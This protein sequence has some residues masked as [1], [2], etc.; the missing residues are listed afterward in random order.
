MSQTQSD[1]P[2]TPFHPLPSFRTGSRNET[3][4]E[5]GSAH[6]LRVATG[7]STKNSSA[8]AIIRNLQEIGGSLS[9]SGD[10]ETISYTVELTRDNLDT[11]M[12]YLSDVVT[13]Q[14]FKPWELE[15]VTNRL[16]V[17]LGQVTGDVW[18]VELLNRA[19]Y[20][21]GLGNSIFCPAHQV[22]KISSE[23]LQHFVANNFTA[24]R[25]A[26]TGVGVC[27]NALSGFAQ[28]LKLAGA[29]GKDSAKSQFRGGQEV[30][31]DKS[32]NWASVAIATEGASWANP[33]DALVSGLFKCAAGTGRSTKWGT[34]NGTV[35]KAVAGAL[36]AN[37]FGFSALS[38]VYADTGLAG[39]VLTADAGSI[40]KGV[41]AALKALRSATVTD[42]DVSRAKAQLK[43][44][45][46]DV[47][48]QDAG[49]AEYL[50]VNGA[51]AKAVPKA[52]EVAAA[53]DGVSAADV[54]A[55]S[56][57]GR[58]KGKGSRLVVN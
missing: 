21:G 15:D 49:M 46:L 28:N 14:T 31:V 45:Y 26:V 32:G 10:R 37:N 12:K 23:T 17:E 57:R 39:F 30:R 56:G 36:G 9:C 11:G 1:I 34:V 22:G 24:G 6:L 50:R 27:H 29:E 41:D 19:S 48:D 18:A 55:V 40:G 13:G 2:E 4:D 42:A 54:N 58:K 20:R 35:G 47:L 25:A 51:M 53:I 38:S 52:S 43:A 3:Y 33:T 16:K 5:Q 44:C 7:L 8:F